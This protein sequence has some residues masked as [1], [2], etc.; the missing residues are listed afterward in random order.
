MEERTL[1]ITI[2]CPRKHK[3]TGYGYLNASGFCSFLFVEYLP[4]GESS[5]FL[6]EKE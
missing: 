3:G 2:L 1:P 6:S 4:V 5:G